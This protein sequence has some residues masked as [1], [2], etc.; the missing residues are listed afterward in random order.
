MKKTTAGSDRKVG[1]NDVTRRY[2]LGDAARQARY[3]AL[4]ESVL[5][6]FVQSNGAMRAAQLPHLVTLEGV[7]SVSTSRPF[8]VA[9]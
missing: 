8:A 9:V 4:L 1:F 7:V 2:V 6:T 3:R 5:Y